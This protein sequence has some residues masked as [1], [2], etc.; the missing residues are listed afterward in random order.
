MTRNRY[1]LIKLLIPVSLALYIVM[2][3]MNFVIE[4]EHTEVFPFF[5]WRLFDNVPGWETS[6][7]GLIVHSIDG[8]EVDG[9]HYLIPSNNVRDWKVLILAVKAC[10]K[11]IDCDETITE[12]LYPIVMQSLGDAKT[13]EFSI[14]KARIDLHDIQN[15]LQD[16]AAQKVRK[17]DFFQPHTLIG[18]WNTQI[19]RIR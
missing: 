3:P 2:I 7:Y 8:D 18:R 17:T 11:D 5:S 4:E 6:E 13:V 10:V 15:N 12:V 9:T 19:G 14:I 16:I 1:Q